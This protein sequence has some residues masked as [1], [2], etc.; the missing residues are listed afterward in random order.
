MGISLSAPERIQA[1][2][3]YCLSQFADRPLLLRAASFLTKP[4]ACSKSAA[5]CAKSS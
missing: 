1:G 5:C 3:L 2:L 4:R